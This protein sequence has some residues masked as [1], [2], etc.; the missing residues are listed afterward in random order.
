MMKDCPIPKV[1]G[2]LLTKPFR[3]RS[4]FKG[5]LKD[6]WT[7]PSAYYEMACLA[8]K[9][10]DFDGVD[11]KVKVAECEEWLK[12]TENVEAYVLETRM[13]F[14]IK[15]SQHTLKKYKEYLGVL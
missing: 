6:D 7:L 3:Y 12:K 14:K 15:T 13:S 9:E 2:C 11:P 1:S 10:K 8:W 5:H 4:K